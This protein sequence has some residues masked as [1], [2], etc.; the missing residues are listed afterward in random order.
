MTEKQYG[1]QARARG[2]L[3]A[4]GFQDRDGDRSTGGQEV[5][6]SP[7]VVARGEGCTE[8]IHIKGGATHSEGGSGALHDGGTVEEGQRAVGVLVFDELEF[9]VERCQIHKVVQLG[10]AETLHGDKVVVREHHAQKA[11]LCFGALVR[12][13]GACKPGGDG[14]TTRSA[15]RKGGQFGGE[16]SAAARLHSD[17][18]RPMIALYAA[19]HTQRV[20]RPHVVI[21][22]IDVRRVG[23]QREAIGIPK[24]VIQTHRA[25]G[26]LGGREDGGQ[27]SL[28]P[29]L[30]PADVLRIHVEV[31]TNENVAGIQGARHRISVHVI[32]QS[33]LHAAHVQ[34]LAKDH[35]DRTQSGL[36]G[37]GQLEGAT[38]GRTLKAVARIHVRSRR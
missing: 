26:G 22:V 2:R 24:V 11:Q 21:K 13:A 4:D 25:D 16:T 30:S 8:G 7:R 33:Q 31:T 27:E 23:Q 29:Q 17:G 15:P 36:L 12:V 38:V 10:G 18:D 6:R 19:Y 5:T 32:Q 20:Y 3:I 9:K 34:V 1:R 14:K 28:G 37:A 35:V